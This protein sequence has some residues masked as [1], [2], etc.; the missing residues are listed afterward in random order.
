MMDAERAR[1]FGLVSHVHP[2]AAVVEHAYRLAASVAAGAPLVNR[3]HKRV[4]QR[5]YDRSPTGDAQGS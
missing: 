2:D 3:W 5:L 4:V 1:T